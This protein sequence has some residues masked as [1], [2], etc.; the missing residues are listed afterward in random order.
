MR[1]VDGEQRNVAALEQRQRALLHAAARARR[2]GDRAP[3]AA[4]CRSISSCVARSSVELRNAALTP[5]IAQRVDLILHQRDQRRHD[6]AGAG[7]DERRD[8][9]AQRLAAAGRHQRQHV[10]A[11]EQRLDDRRLVQSGSS[12]SRRL[13][14]EHALR[15]GHR[16]GGGGRRG[17][18][19]GSLGGGGHA[20]R[21]SCDVSSCS[22]RLHLVAQFLPRSGATSRRRGR[23]PQEIRGRLQ[24]TP[25][26]PNTARKLN[27]RREPHSVGVHAAE[28][29]L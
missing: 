12:C 27:G 18:L 29:S 7:P 1:L 23:C 16:R 22:G 20:C 19:G 26:R 4:N 10:A 14:L 9:V 11:G 6:D 17:F 5:S 2:R 28:A 3:P 13:L 25:P 24:A 21:R 15:L 8:L